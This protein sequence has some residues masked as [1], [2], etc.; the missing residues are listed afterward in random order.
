MCLDLDQKPADT[1][2]LYLHGVE[3]VSIWRR[4]TNRGHRYMKKETHSNT[5]AK[6]KLVLTHFLDKQTP[7]GRTSYP[8]EIKLPDEMPPTVFCKS[9]KAKSLRAATRYILTAELSG[10]VA[11][12]QD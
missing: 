10:G 3:D 8:F 5:F 12:R 9:H 7:V 6:V 4:H 2:T 1:L 11:I